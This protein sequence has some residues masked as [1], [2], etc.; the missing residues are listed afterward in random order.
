MREEVHTVN[1]ILLLLCHPTEV[2]SW[3]GAQPRRTAVTPKDMLVADDGQ[4]TSL[5]VNE[6]TG[7]EERRVYALTIFVSRTEVVGVARVSSGFV[8]VAA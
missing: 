7:E 1:G 5:V 6:T 8:G 4:E 3:L 2:F